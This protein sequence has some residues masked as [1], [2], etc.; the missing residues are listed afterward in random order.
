MESNKT[1]NWYSDL[2][3]DCNNLAER[4]GLDDLHMDEL[5][6]FVE[7]IARNQFISGSKS[8]YRWAKQGG[9]KKLVTAPQ[10]VA[11]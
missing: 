2:I 7:K 6:N 4:F 10:A 5:R 11:A 9:D 3:R 1:Q 8:G